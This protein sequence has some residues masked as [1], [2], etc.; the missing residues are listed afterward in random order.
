EMNWPR[1]TRRM[2][3]SPLK[4][5]RI[6]FC[7]IS[8][9]CAS[10][11]AREL[12]AVATR[13]CISSSETSWSR[14]SC[15]Q[16]SACTSASLAAVSSDLSVASSLSV[17]RRTSTSPALTGCPASNSI[18]RTT[19]PASVVTSVPLTATR[20]PTASLSSLQ[21]SVVAVAALTAA[22]G[23]GM[24]SKN[25]LVCAPIIALTANTPPNTRAVPSS[26]R[27]RRSA[28]R[29]L[30]FV[31]A[32]GMAESSV[33]ETSVG[34]VRAG[35][36]EHVAAQAFDRAV[37]RIVVAGIEQ[38][39]PAIAVEQVVQVLEQQP[40]G[41]AEGRIQQSLLLCKRMHAQTQDPWADRQPLVGQGQAGRKLATGARLGGDGIDQARQRFAGGER[42][43]AARIGRRAPDHI[44]P[45]ELRQAKMLGLLAQHDQVGQCQ[46][47][48]AVAGR[49]LPSRGAFE[50]L[51]P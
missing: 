28:N 2:P 17:F 34:R 3:S 32:V 23:C 18:A 40:V 49:P 48:D 43:L 15:C 26:I 30:R 24:L 45:D 12:A 37:Q 11:C 36:V 5:A 8:A 19:P 44:G 13:C 41:G 29:G 21:R 47:D 10:A 50:Q 35:G 14:P 20:V 33:G 7:A 38:R 25:L 6:V 27:I 1:L 22:A 51:H 46:R 39:L 42:A 4:G 31:V 16:R 9:R